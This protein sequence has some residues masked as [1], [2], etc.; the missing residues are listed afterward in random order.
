MA[1]VTIEPEVKET[2]TFVPVEYWN[3]VWPNEQLVK[4]DPGP[5]GKD[6]DPVYEKSVSFLAGYFRATEPWQVELIENNARDRAFKADLRD[7][8]AP[9]RCAK[10]G[11]ETRSSRAFMHH[12]AQES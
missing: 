5:M 6:Y 8:E 9:M 4:R 3:A 1:T 7:D 11:W 10:C 2:T 12:T